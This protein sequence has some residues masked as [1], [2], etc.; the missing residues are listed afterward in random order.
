M[1]AQIPIDASLNLSEETADFLLFLLKEDRVFVPKLSIPQVLL[2]KQRAGLSPDI[3]AASIISRFK[4]I[5]IP[6][7]PLAGG[8]TNVMENFVR[9]ISE[10]LVDAIQNDMRIDVVTDA[11]QTINGNGANAGGPIVVVGST[12]VPH[13]GI[14]VAR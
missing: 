6:T 10:E 14:G 2:A 13:T 3:L 9:V 8:A 7:G 11:G 4:E 5:G 12:V 1:A